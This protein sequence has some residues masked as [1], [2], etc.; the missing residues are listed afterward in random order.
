MNAKFNEKTLK[1]L[2]DKALLGFA[3]NWISTQVDM[4]AWRKTNTNRYARWCYS[5]LTRYEFST[6]MVHSKYQE[7]PMTVNQIMDFLKI[8]R[9][10]ADALIKTCIEEVWIEAV[11]HCKECN[12]VCYQAHNNVIQLNLAFMDRYASTINE[13]DRDAAYG[14]YA[15]L[16]RYEECL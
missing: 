15:A 14:L 12:S 3:S 1:D 13:Q 8:T 10:T 2:K 5:S 11:E 7:A 4:I 16:K 6:L 9:K